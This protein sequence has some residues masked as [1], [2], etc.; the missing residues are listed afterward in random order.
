MTAAQLK[1]KRTMESRFHRRLAY[2]VRRTR[3]QCCVRHWRR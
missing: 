2:H 3:T 1:E